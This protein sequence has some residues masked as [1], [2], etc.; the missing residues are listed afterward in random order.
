M[1]R[2][3]TMPGQYVLEYYVDRT[4]RKLKGSIDLDQCEQVRAGVTTGVTTAL[5]QPYHTNQRVS[6][7]GR[8][9]SDVRMRKDPFPVYV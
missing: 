2:Q 8:L 1:L 3:G 5:S 9:W 4:A 6:S 7:S